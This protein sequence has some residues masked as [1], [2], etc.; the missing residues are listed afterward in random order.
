MFVLF[1]N[2]NVDILPSLNLKYIASAV[3]NKTDTDIGL[4]IKS[5]K[6]NTYLQSD[7]NDFYGTIEAGIDRTVPFNNVN[8]DG[9]FKIIATSGN[10]L[11][12]QSVNGSFMYNVLALTFNPVDGTSIQKVN[13]VHI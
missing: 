7:I 12:M 4:N 1:F 6:N 9:K 10:V 5:Y 3:Y 11:H 2:N 8:V 13:H